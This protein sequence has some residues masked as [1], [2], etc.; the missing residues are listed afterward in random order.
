[1]E[2]II[3]ALA[4]MVAGVFVSEGSRKLE[5]KKQNV[6]LRQQLEDARRSCQK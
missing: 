4:A 5:Q 6:E 3:I 2:L 1:M